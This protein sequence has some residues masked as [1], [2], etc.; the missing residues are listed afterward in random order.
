MAMRDFWNVRAAGGPID[1]HRT[2]AVLPLAA[3]EQHG[4]HLP[5]T[6]D[7]DIAAGLMDA[8]AARLPAD[9]DVIALPVETVGASRE[10]ERF[11]GLASVSTPALIDRIVAIGGELAGLG[12]RK[13]ALIS[14]HGG[15]VAAMMAAALDLR[16]DA[17]MLAVATTWMRLG[18]PDG[19]IDAREQAFGIHG[20]QVE[21]S[22][23]LHFRPDL[24]DMA[25]ARNFPSTQAYLADR[26]E[27]L[28]AHGPV[29]FGWL[30]GDLNGAG[31][32]G[33]AA[34]ATAAIGAAIAGHQATRFCRLLA[35]MADVDLAA[36]LN[37]DV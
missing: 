35:E 13:L 22:L 36:V 14:S 34:A 23:M 1:A 15:N 8:T 17:A 27:L 19:L 5:A 26:Y 16:A 4:P 24:V 21:T 31:V 2:V 28:R 11:A 37:G 25:A 18:L 12:V 7:A 33:N 32:V 10:H 3:T 20:G 6:T 29:G 9:A 30:A